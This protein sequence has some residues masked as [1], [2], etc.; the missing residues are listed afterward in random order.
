MCMYYGLYFYHDMVCPTK[1]FV[2]YFTK[3]IKKEC[4]IQNIQYW[5]W[6]K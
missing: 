1:R 4:N 3:N 2:E 6:T 5:L